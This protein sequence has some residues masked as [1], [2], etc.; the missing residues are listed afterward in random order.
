MLRRIS[1][2]TLVSL[3][4]AAPS[5]GQAVSEFRTAQSLP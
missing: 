2:V 3:A 1:S 5:A 4:A